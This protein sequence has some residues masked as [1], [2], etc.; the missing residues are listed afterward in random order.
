MREDPWEP[1]LLLVMLLVCVSH[2][3]H[4]HRENV[5]LHSNRKI[6]EQSSLFCNVFLEPPSIAPPLL[7]APHAMRPR[8]SRSH[9]PLWVL[10]KQTWESIFVQNTP[11]PLCCRNLT[12]QIMRTTPTHNEARSIIALIGLSMVASAKAGGVRPGGMPTARRMPEMP[13]IQV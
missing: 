5:V 11:W 10:L 2:N 8:H 3:L 4:K 12:V 13:D 1:T 9:T 7:T 6:G